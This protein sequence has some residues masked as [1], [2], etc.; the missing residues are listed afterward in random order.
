MIRALPQ[1]P[2][3][4]LKLLQT[5]LLVA[6]YLHHLLPL[7][8]L[9]NVAVDRS[10]VFL[11]IGKIPGGTIAQLRGDPQ[12]N[13]RHDHGNRRQRKIQNHHADKGRYQRDAGVK[14]L[15]KTLADKLA[16]SIHI[17][18]IHGHNIAVG[19]GVKIPD[20]QGLHVGKK[21]H[22]Q[23]LHGSLAHI[24]HNPVV[25]VGA[26]DAHNQHRRQL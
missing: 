1:L 24:D 10:Q 22:T 15:G 9:L 16:Q 25:G 8:H 19:M 6:E 11:L 14:Q 23:P 4:L 21:L 2:V 26:K 3:Q 17:V 20:G 12:H 7:H 18:G 5:F 13:S